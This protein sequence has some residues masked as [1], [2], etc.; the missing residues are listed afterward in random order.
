[1][2]RFDHGEVTMIDGGHPF[3]SKAFGHRDDRRI[4]RAERKI[5]IP[6]DQI[7]H[8]HRID[9]NKRD[10]FEGSACRL[11][12]ERRFNLWPVLQKP[13]DFGENRAG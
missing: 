10:K 8:T 2:A 3:R 4:H 1:M 5:R 13:A 9:I 7:R 11:V 12:K 6:T